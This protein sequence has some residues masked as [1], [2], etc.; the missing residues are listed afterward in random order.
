MR[1]IGTSCDNKFISSICLILKFY[2]YIYTITT[3]FSL[4]SLQTFKNTISSA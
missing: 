2:S 3:E 1:E 4:K